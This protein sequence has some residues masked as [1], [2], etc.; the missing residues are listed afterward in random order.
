[1]RL[2]KERRVMIYTSYI[3]GLKLVG[4]SIKISLILFIVFVFD[5][6]EICPLMAPTT[7]YLTK[8][9]PVMMMSGEPVAG[10]THYR[11]WLKY[12]PGYDFLFDSCDQWN[13]KRRIVPE[14]EA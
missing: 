2:K 6:R 10:I 8:D 9:Q 1:M 5:A 11:S 4:S 13:K 12:W 7:G 3:I 14:D